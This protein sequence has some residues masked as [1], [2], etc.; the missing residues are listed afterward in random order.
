MR[1]IF[2][3]EFDQ[4][5]VFG[6]DLLRAFAI[7]FVVIGHGIGL[8]PSKIGAFVSLFMY[9]GV[10]MFFVLSG[11]L[12]GGILIKLFDDN[13]INLHN[14]KKFWI[15][16]WFRTLPNYFFILLILC[17]LHL[18]FGSDFTFWSV[19]RYF[20]FSQN[21]FTNHP[22]W[23]FPE[24]WSLSVEEWFY[25]I[26]PLLVIGLTILLKNSIKQGVLYTCILVI[27]AIT[28][29][30]FYRY[31]NVALNDIGEWDLMFRKQVSTRLDSLMFGVL[32]A[33]MN[34][35]Y[36]SLWVKYKNSLLFIG[37][38]I[39]LLTKFVIPRYTVFN[40][41]YTCVFVFNLISIATLFLLPYLNE[42]KKGKGVF[43][44]PITY[45]SLTSY[46]MYLINLTLVQRWI[47]G[48]ISWESL[49]NNSYLVWI[50]RYGFY[51]VLVIG[52][53]ILIYKYFELPMMALRDKFGNKPLAKSVNT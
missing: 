31:S 48:Q 16:R 12:I 30:R 5:R 22:M 37:I 15:R 8:L 11:F 51:W 29:F 50:L 38:A 1:N 4:N 43:Y 7:L 27:V 47:I 14:L 24:A 6:L 36:Y 13:G 28:L 32:G 34:Y 41:I 18:F 23:F 52:L 46:S 3:I 49:I 25:L 9:D 35:Y 21:I 20:I 19:N 42:L 40:D 2:K 26:L 33:Y 39:Y 53:S 17:L 10:S 45:I 44:K